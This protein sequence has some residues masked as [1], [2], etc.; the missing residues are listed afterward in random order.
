MN[1]IEEKNLVSIDDIVVDETKD[2][3]VEGGLDSYKDLARQAYE[4]AVSQDFDMNIEADRKALN[5]WSRKF[6]SLVKRFTDLGVADRKE[7]RR[8]MEKS[9]EVE[10]DFTAYVNELKT[11]LRK[12]LD[13]W[14]E[15]EAERV[16]QLESRVRE[17]V[18]LGMTEMVPAP[19]L[20]SAQLKERLDALG[21]I[22]LN[23]T[24]EEFLPEA[25]EAYLL[26]K[27][28]L[29]AL[30]ESTVEAEE[31]QAEL[32]ELKRK[33]REAE[34]EQKV[35]E[36][37]ERARKEAEERAEKEKNEAIEAVEREV[38]EKAEAEQ[39]QREAE[40]AEA[41]RKAENVEHRASVNRQTLA[42]LM[43]ATNIDEA[44][45]KRVIKA[46]AKGLVSRVSINY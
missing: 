7:A 40:E 42:D 36:A 30:Y 21:G 6:G 38:K 33:Q 3:F 23:E 18:D 39:R 12:P 9:K 19:K 5:S 2:L 13:E 34:H 15:R 41:K 43:S 22:E 35:K 16:K 26:A 24:F 32:E 11:D 10:N 46:I 25:E 17:I 4:Y 27:Q 31:Q 8:I 28:N 29:T 44:T 37:E 1:A 45:A 20:D 14:K